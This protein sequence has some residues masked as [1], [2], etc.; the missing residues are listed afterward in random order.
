MTGSLPRFKCWSPHSF[1][2][3]TMG[4]SSV[5]RPGSRYARPEP[6]GTSGDGDN[7][8]N[9]GRVAALGVE[10]VRGADRE[11]VPETWLRHAT[12]MTGRIAHIAW[13]PD[14]N[15][16]REAADRPRSSP[17]RNPRTGEQPRSSPRLGAPRM[18]PARTQG[19]LP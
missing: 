13:A 10:N 7:V 12:I 2:A 3:R 4:R 1:N 8:V 17:E 9:A 19:Q 15:R 5:A 16:A 11:L 6:F 18:C 14:A